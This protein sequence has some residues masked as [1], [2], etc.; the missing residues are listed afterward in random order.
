MLLG[1]E[2][3]GLMSLLRSGVGINMV[4]VEDIKEVLDTRFEYYDVPKITDSDL[5]KMVIY[6]NEFIEYPSYN[7]Y[8]ESVTIWNCKEA[9]DI[10]NLKQVAIFKAIQYIIAHKYIEHE[11][12]QCIID[13]SERF[14]GCILDNYFKDTVLIGD[15]E[16]CK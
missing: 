3:N 10:D 13:R 14:M 15:E 7:D 1:L 6:A 5:D 8:Y 4:T 9:G 16:E 12:A 11:D 2:E